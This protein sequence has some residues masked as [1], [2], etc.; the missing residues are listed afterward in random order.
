M[1]PRAVVLD[2]ELIGS[3]SRDTIAASEMRLHYPVDRIIYL[4]VSVGCSTSIGA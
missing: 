2:P 4:P 3:C 1:V